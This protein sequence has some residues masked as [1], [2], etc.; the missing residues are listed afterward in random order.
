MTNAKLRGA[1]LVTSW[2]LQV[3][4]AGALVFMG[5]VPKLLGMFPAPQIFQELGVEPWGRYFVG[6]WEGLAVVLLLIPRTA[7]WGAVLAVLGMAGAFASHATKLGFYPQFTNA[8]TGEVV[9]LPWFF[10]VALLV[11]GLV[12]LYL[13]R[14][15]LPIVGRRL[16][17]GDDS[18][19]ARTGDE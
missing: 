16:A 19:P 10:S 4:L 5:A 8:Q 11:V 15:A 1:G 18:A 12:V 7:V 3:A 14:G 6:G 2:V 9:T 13:R 17:K